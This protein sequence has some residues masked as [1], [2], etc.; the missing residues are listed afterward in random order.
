MN[1][2]TRKRDWRASDARLPASGPHSLSERTFRQGDVPAVRRFTR[3]FGVRAGI[4]A[5][6]LADFVLA[7]SEA[8]ACATGVG[9]CTARVR[10]WMAGSRAFCEVHGD[11]LLLQN[12]PRG[13]RPGEEEAMRRRVLR[14]LS[15]FVSIASGPDG[16][17]VQLSMRVA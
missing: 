13:P 5:A 17:W 6:R 16:V 1:A 10:L 14:Q 3:A 2:D 8:A 9:P 15:D 12:S 7:V 4:G 11:G